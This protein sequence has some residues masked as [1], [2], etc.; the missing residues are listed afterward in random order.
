[1]VRRAVGTDLDLN[2]W[3]EEIVQGIKGQWGVTMS[4]QDVRAMM[5]EHY[6]EPHATKIQYYMTATNAKGKAKGKPWLKS[7]LGFKGFQLRFD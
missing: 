5:L 7:A 1:M 3:I 4:S 2:L 6:A